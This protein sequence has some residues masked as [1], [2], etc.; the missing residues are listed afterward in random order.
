MVIGRVFEFLNPLAIAEQTITAIHRSLGMTH[1]YL[2]KQMEHPASIGSSVFRVSMDRA[3]NPL[4]I[5]IVCADW[6][7]HLQTFGGLEA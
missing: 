7:G 6:P 4:V 1:C 2:S 3:S 5:T